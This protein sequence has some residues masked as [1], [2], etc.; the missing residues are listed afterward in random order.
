LRKLNKEMSLL[1]E[2]NMEVKMAKK[3]IIDE[4]LCEGCE[5]CVELCPDVFE[6]GESGKARVKNPNALDTCNIEE[7][8]DSCPTGALKSEE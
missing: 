4:D 6:L 2:K 8:I 3:I 5:T 7:A 1:Q